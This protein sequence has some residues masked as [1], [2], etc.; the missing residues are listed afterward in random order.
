M[1]GQFIGMALGAWGA[2]Q[3]A[4]A[5]IAM[6]FGGALRDGVSGMVGH[7]AWGPTMTDP[8]L[9]YSV[10]YHVEMLFLFITLIAIGPLVKRSTRLMPVVP[11]NL[12]LAELRT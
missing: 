3:S 5:G 4:A 11:P 12:G 2:V 8:S 7:G 10:V 6:F 9:A 1:E